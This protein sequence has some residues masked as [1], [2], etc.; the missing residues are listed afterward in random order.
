MK[1]RVVIV[2][3]EPAIRGLLQAYLSPLPL[4]VRPAKDAAE[5][6]ELAAQAPHPA[7]VI[8]D[9]EMPGTSGVELL[10]SLKKLDETIQ[11]VMVTGVQQMGTVRE[12]V[13]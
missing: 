2:D 3:D 10:Q 13:R 11:V 7:L 8:S 12:C 9:I 5:A 1:E 4:D 6:L